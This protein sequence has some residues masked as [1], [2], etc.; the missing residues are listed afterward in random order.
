MKFITF[1]MVCCVASCVVS[2]QD[3]ENHYQELVKSNYYCLPCQWA[4]KLI[5]NYVNNTQVKLDQFIT[6]EC[7]EY[8]YDSKVICPII[9]DSL[10]DLIKYSEQETIPRKVCSLAQ[11]CLANSDG[12]HTELTCSCCP[13]R[14]EV[15]LVC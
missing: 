9:V 15:R 14:C 10:K 13:R 11:L 6:N 8:M 3:V 1:I 7:Y 12:C 5:Q 2:G 4:V